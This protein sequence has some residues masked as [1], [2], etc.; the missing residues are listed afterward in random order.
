MDISILKGHTLKSIES[1]VFNEELI[2]TTSED[3]QY[4]MYHEKDCCES[5]S[6]EEIIGDLTDLIGNPILTAESRTKTNP[7]EDR[8]GYR[9]DGEWTF[10]ELATIKGSVT[11][12]W[13]GESDYY[14]VSINFAEIN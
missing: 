7:T 11:I 4:K 13:Y 2:F 3:K 5:V 6:I 14:S 10:Y 12:R 8:E 1:G 9:E